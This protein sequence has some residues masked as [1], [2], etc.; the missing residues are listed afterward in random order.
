MQQLSTPLARLPK[1]VG[2]QGV[3]AHKSPGRL[4]N[5]AKVASIFLYLLQYLD[6]CLIVQSFSF[7]QAGH[8]E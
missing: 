1:R 7:V 2:G 3:R 6:I 4:R 5:A 8:N